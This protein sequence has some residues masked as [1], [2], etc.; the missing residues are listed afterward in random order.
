M[1]LLKYISDFPFNSLFLF[2]FFCT[3]SLLLGKFLKDIELITLIRFTHQLAYLRYCWKI[4]IY[5]KGSLTVIRLLKIRQILQLA[6]AKCMIFHYVANKQ[7][8]IYYYTFII[9]SYFKITKNS[10]T[11]NVRKK[12]QM[13]DNGTTI[14]DL[15]FE[16]G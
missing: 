12:W 6:I 7:N 13:V 16:P 4:H 10:N 15:S 14:I 3:S 8:K 2:S 1:C 9:S 11:C 5:F